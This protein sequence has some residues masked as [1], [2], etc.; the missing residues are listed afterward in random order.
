M[1]G[2]PRSGRCLTCAKRK[3][4]CDEAWPTCGA[5]KRSKKVCPGPPSSK[6]KFVHNGH[7]TVATYN[8][9]EDAAATDTTQAGD[10]VSNANI[11][12]Q[13]LGSL[14]ETKLT[15]AEDGRSFRRLRLKPAHPSPRLVRLGDGD[16]SAAQLISVIRAC[17]D[18]GFDVCLGSA[19]DSLHMMGR[20]M[21]HNSPVLQDAVGAM[22]ASWTN[23][24]RGLRHEH[25]LD[26]PSYFKS[27]SSINEALNKESKEGKISLETYAA[28]NYDLLSVTNSAKHAAGLA[29]IMV[30]RGPPQSHDTIDLLLGL[31][32]FMVLTPE[33]VG[34]LLGRLEASITE[35]RALDAE[36]ILPDMRV[37]NIRLVPSP[38][39]GRD[40][41]TPGG[42]STPFKE[43]YEF[44]GWN[45][46]TIF[47]LHAFCLVAMNRMLNDVYHFIGR[48]PAS[49][50]CKTNDDEAR[51]FSRRIWLSHEHAM[52]HWPL[53]STQTKA[54]MILA[55]EAGDAVERAY[56][57]QGLRDLNRHRTPAGTSVD[58]VWTDP[59]VLYAGRQVTGRNPI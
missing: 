39:T 28:F 55:Y 20:C 49:F 3:V 13:G 11:N 15:K 4:K 59:M 6:L 31:Q 46:S 29:A 47:R 53:G 30:M 38:P 45:V 18:T 54:N 5:C 23:L 24:R 9:D 37:G 35:L 8:E 33:I 10:Q 21:S 42:H 50:E 1:V 43:H 14:V 12:P 2:V 58:D 7:H 51:R 27:I 48:D 41:E 40:G 32:N 26:A 57:L 25:V 22:V 36:M 17:P 16:R 44:S 19:L 56:V 52:R 34:E